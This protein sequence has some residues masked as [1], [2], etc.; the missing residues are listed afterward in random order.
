MKRNLINIVKFLRLLILK[1]GL[2]RGVFKLFKLIKKSGGTEPLRVVGYPEVMWFR[3]GGSDVHLIKNIIY[4]EEYNI[5]LRGMVPKNIID[6]GA[7]VGYTSVFFANTF[8]QANVLAFEPEDENF[9]MLQR[10]VAPYSNISAFK[11]GVWGRDAELVAA[12][13][14]Y[15][16]WSFSLKESGEVDQKGKFKVVSV[17]NILNRISGDIDILKIDIE[18]AEIEIFTPEHADWLKRVKVIVIELH[19]RKIKGC[20]EA[21]YKSLVDN[22]ISFTQK[23]V[24]YNTILYNEA[25]FKDVKS[26]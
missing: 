15:D 17:S 19:D 20:S 5:N 13:S 22:N 6:V 7:N 8:P 23:V 12:E 9:E 1:E 21:F 10:N 4:A 3:P 25:F 24:S 26:V 11:E 16:S 2:F 18:G 14:S